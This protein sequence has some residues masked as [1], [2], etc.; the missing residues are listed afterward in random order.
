MT[1]GAA[2]VPQKAIFTHFSDRLLRR[3]RMVIE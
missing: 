3:E 1:A 2:R